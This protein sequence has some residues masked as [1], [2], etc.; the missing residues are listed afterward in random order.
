L[1]P[2]RYAPGAQSSTERERVN[3]GLCAKELNRKLKIF[4]I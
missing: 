3:V 4:L 1:T 2:L